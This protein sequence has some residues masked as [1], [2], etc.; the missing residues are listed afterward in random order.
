MS[1]TT[2][3]TILTTESTSTANAAPSLRERIS[4]LQF[5]MLHT[6]DVAAARAFYAERMGLTVVTEAP[7]FVQFASPTGK[8][9]DLA[10]GTLTPEVSREPELWW[11]VDDVD[12]THAT[13]LAQGA[14]I[15]APLTTMPFGR[16]C[17]T[18]DPA[19]YT[20]YLLQLA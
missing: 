1:D 16:F 11:Y 12:T 13:L 10:I 6:D 3:A 7:G 9:A 8:G 2:N 19:G 15:V 20:V 5:V 17:A 18:K 14:E 4:G